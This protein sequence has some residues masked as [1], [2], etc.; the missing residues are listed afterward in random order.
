[1]I[2]ATIRVPIPEAQFDETLERFYAAQVAI[3]P[4]DDW[5]MRNWTADSNGHSYSFEGFRLRRGLALAVRDTLA[6][7]CS[8]AWRFTVGEIDPDHEWIE[9]HGRRQHLVSIT[10]TILAAALEDADWM[11][12]LGHRLRQDPTRPHW[13]RPD[14]WPTPDA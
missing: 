9:F 3:V 4:P 12:L 7:S 13:S 8:R 2:A 10:P 1:M 11:G 14:A 5:E 6:R